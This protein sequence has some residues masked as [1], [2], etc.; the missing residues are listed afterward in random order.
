MQR[1]EVIIEPMHR[2][3]RHEHINGI[4]ALLALIIIIIILIYSKNAKSR[5]NVP[6]AGPSYN[7]TAFVPN[8]QIDYGG[9]YNNNS[10][11]SVDT[12]VGHEHN[13]NKKELFNTIKQFN[14]NFN[15]KFSS[16][17]NP[18]NLDAYNVY[19]YG[20]PGSS[21][22]EMIRTLDKIQD[23]AD[24]QDH[25]TAHQPEISDET[26][27]HD[28]LGRNSDGSLGNSESITVM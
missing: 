27:E 13:S 4:I 23:L 22:R 20:T 21:Q 12:R 1:P 24:V 6:N 16:P 2:G 11:S 17:I 14:K 3:Y 28:Q 5:L 10:F 8:G 9:N 19:L 26:L 18:T 25:S 15:E 7:P